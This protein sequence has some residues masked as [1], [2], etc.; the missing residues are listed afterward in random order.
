MLLL[1][2]FS[3]WHRVHL[4]QLFE[5]SGR[6]DI[7]QGMLKTFPDTTLW[8]SA[9]EDLHGVRVLAS[10]VP[11]LMS[12]ALDPPDYKCL[13]RWLVLGVEFEEW[14]LQY[15]VEFE[16]YPTPRRTLWTEAVLLSADL[17][18]LQFTLM[19]LSCVYFDRRPGLLS[20][21]DSCVAIILTS[22]CS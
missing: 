20:T 4:A 22:C 7:Q 2:W 13:L 14:H 10:T 8:R 15:P 18:P 6:F 5:V 11:V 9:V 16:G 17:V 21:G 19:C 12:L 1:D 3:V